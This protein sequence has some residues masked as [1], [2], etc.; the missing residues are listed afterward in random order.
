MHQ[1]YPD[2]SLFPIIKQKKQTFLHPNLSFSPILCKMIKREQTELGRKQV[3]SFLALF[4]HSL[5]SPA[6]LCLIGWLAAGYLAASCRASYGPSPY[7]VILVLSSSQKVMRPFV[8][9][10]DQSG[11]FPPFKVNGRKRFVLKLRRVWDVVLNKTSLVGWK[12][13]LIRA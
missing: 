2:I 3:D 5:S 10:A 8:L 7:W 9:S 13:Y 6:Q 1:F 4:C 11:E 12:I